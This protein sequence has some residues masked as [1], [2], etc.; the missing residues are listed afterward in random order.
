M[1][2]GD[3]EIQLSFIWFGCEKELGVFMDRSLEEEEL[4]PQPSRLRWRGRQQPRR[5]GRDVF[6]APQCRRGEQTPREGKKEHR[7]SWGRQRNFNKSPAELWDTVPARG[8]PFLDSL[9]IN[10][11][12]LAGFYRTSPPGENNH[13]TPKH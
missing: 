5:A 10:I 2:G 13:Q 9:G 1:W 12:R 11:S 6:V 7:R 3:N 8:K 4:L